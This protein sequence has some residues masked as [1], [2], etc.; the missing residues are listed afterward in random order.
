MNPFTYDKEERTTLIFILILACIIMVLPNWIKPTR[1]VISNDK[2]QKIKQLFGTEPYQPKW[3]GVV[4]PINYI[5]EDSL[6]ALGIEHKLAK[7]IIRFREVIGQYKSMNDFSKIYGMPDSIL[8]EVQLSFAAPHNKKASVPKSSAQLAFT[9]TLYINLVDAHDLAAQFGFTNK[10]AERIIKYR[11]SIK[12]YKNRT[13]LSKVYGINKQHINRLKIDYRPRTI[14]KTSEY[15]V[16]KRK[17][18]KE[19][20]DV[21]QKTKIKINQLTKTDLIDLGI[22]KSLA[23]RIYKYGKLIGGYR[24]DT[25]LK[26]VY[27]MTDKLLDR[28]HWQFDTIALHHNLD[29]GMLDINMVT[30]RDLI[31]IRGIGPVFARRI[32]RYRD[33]LGGFCDKSQVR[34]TPKLSTEGYKAIKNYISIK[35]PCQ[36]MD[37]EQMSYGQ[38][39][40][41]PYITTSQAGILVNMIRDSMPINGDLLIETGVMSEKEWMRLRPYLVVD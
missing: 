20:K 16:N 38:L 17:Q 23:H 4:I 28:Y 27:A 11:E 41:H 18:K 14:K 10:L 34:E 24:S 32:I 22:E 7:R 33:A 19:Y 37:L 9:D 40:N 21:S 26:K 6:V 36:K 12:G 1:Q 25:S 39:S 35:T 5:T 15:S 8:T 29:T 30:V 13:S 2:I 3:K 31:A